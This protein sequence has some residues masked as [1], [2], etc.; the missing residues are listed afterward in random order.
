MPNTDRA[1]HRRNPGLPDALARADNQ[2]VRPQ[3]LADVYTNP[4]AELA[5]MER[6]GLVRRVAHGYYV[7]VP[8]AERG[9]HWRADVEKV[10]LGIAVAE[11]GHDAAAL[12]GITAAR[13]LGAVPRALN[14][15]VVAIP[16]QRPVLETEFGRVHFVKR[17]IPT[18]DLQRVRTLLVEGYVTTVEQTVLD[19]VAR[20]TLGGITEATAHEAV[21][22]LWPR[23]DQERVADLARR[24][25]KNRAL[26]TLRTLVE[27]AP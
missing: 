21:R 20:P 8:E 16:R 17:A 18:L 19:L 7:V 25:L 23:C 1:M 10:A 9:G 24:Q 14:T 22:M 12:M 2:V 4:A 3:D 15:A 26:R 27:P 11:Y 6:R 5:R 13:V